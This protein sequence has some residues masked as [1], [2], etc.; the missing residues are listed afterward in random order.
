MK[1]ILIT[2]GNGQL[3]QCFRKIEHK[4]TDSYIFIYKSSAELDVTKED[5]VMSAIKALAPDF[6]INCAAYTAVDKAE[7][8]TELAFSVN[9][10]GAGNLAKACKSYK[11]L[12]VHISTD[13][14][15]GDVQAMPLTEI[16]ET[17]P[18][19]V[20]GKSKIAGEHKIAENLTEYFII[21]TSWLYS[22]YQNNFVKTMLRLGKERDELSV[23]FD[24]V[25]TPTYAV[26]LAECVMHIIVSGAKNFGVYNY[27][28]EGVASWY[29][30]AFAIFSIT[31]IKTDLKPITSDQYPTPARRP[32]YS[33]MNKEK[34]KRVFNLQINHWT[35]SLTQCLNNIK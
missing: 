31:G 17:I 30:F 16:S 32:N 26:D 28:N 6:V 14:V 18:F 35:E 4:F 2:G 22:E 24:Q 34:I 8:E 7:Q 25:G 3:G 15:F 33:V 23:V 13:F 27:S 21:R 1:K 11:A 10:N 5:T 29:D 9:E 20:Y 19:G 12:L